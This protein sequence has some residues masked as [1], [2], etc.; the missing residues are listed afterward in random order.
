[1][2]IHLVRYNRKYLT[3]I[4]ALFNNTIQQVN[5]EDYSQAELN[6]WIQSNPNY[7]LWHENL[8][9]SYCILVIKAGN[10]V[11]FGNITIE[12]YIDL[13]YVSHVMIHQ[14]VGRLLFNE[15]EK[16]AVLESVASIYTDASITA[17]PFF[18]KM[19]LDLMRKQDNQRNNEN[20]INYRMEKKLV[21][22]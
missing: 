12:G 4:V 22:R 5:R 17:T 11:G 3:A 13:F 16:Y 6:E 1:M 9:S 18:R 8:E 7:D 21:T 19:G 2:A 10:L 20:L 14:G 15:L